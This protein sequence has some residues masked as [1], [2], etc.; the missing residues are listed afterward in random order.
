MAANPRL[1]CDDSV[2]M[3]GRSPSREMVARTCFSAPMPS[4]SPQPSFSEPLLQHLALGAACALRSLLSY[5]VLGK[6]PRV[7]NE[8]RYAPKGSELWAHALSLCTVCSHKV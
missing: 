7:F 3:K 2:A 5:A 4:C 6:V 8:R 1:C